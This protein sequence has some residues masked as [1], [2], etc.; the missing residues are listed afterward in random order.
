MFHGTTVLAVR[1]QGQGAMAG[2]GQITMGQA[3]I[4]KHGARKVR[5]IWNGKVLAGFAGAL[6]D[7]LTLFEKFEAR[8]EESRGNLPRAAV[9]VARDWRTDRV[10]RHLEAL[11]VVMDRQNL[12]VVSGSGEVVEPDDGIA[13]VGSGGP[14]ALAA[15]RALVRNSDLPARRIAEESLRIA[16]SICVYTNDQLTL[17]EVEA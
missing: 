13:A 15:A 8:L 12:L 1:H 17:E 11:L 2:D 4:M 16:A 5:R 9:T 10:L 7:A 6:A 14:F 3:T